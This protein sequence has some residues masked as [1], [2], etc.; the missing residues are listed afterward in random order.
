[1]LNRS[2]YISGPPE[3]RLRWRQI[4]GPNVAVKLPS[5]LLP[6]PDHDIFT[7]VEE[8]AVA[9][10]H[11]VSADLVDRSVQLLNLDWLAVEGAD[12]HVDTPL[13]EGLNGGAAC[14]RCTVGRQQLACL[15]V[16]RCDA[17]CITLGKTRHELLVR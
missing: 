6:L 11:F 4:A 15:N 8:L 2:P 12:A 5:A 7:H 14:N 3:G 9:P 10:I 16:E 17:G 13:P 1:M